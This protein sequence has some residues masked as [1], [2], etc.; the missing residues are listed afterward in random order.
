MRRREAYKLCAENGMSQ[1][2]INSDHIK[3]TGE[4]VEQ[5]VPD[6][7]TAMH[8]MEFLEEELEEEPEEIF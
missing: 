5:K 2:H 6:Y 3:W 7:M 4:T 8:I 1:I